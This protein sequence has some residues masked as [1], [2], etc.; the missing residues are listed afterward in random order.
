MFHYIKQI[1]P[2]VFVGEI[3]GDILKATKLGK[4]LDLIGRGRTGAVFLV[5]INQIVL[6]MC[7]LYNRV[8]NKSILQI[9]RIRL[10]AVTTTKRL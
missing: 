2:W 1:H 4:S 8:S 10:S 5:P 6:Y 7:G 9:H 3:L